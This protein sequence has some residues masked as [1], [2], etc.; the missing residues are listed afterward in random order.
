M[1]HEAKHG[2][3]DDGGVERGEGVHRAHDQGVPVEKKT[4]KYIE[5]IQQNTAADYIP[6]AV[7]VELVVGSKCQE[8]SDTDAVRVEDLVN[9]ETLVI[10]VDDWKFFPLFSPGSLRRSSTRSW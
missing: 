8:S 3:D 4:I 2:E 5:V 6:I 1:G 9:G 7:L 10:C